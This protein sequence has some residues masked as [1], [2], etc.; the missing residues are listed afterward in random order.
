[1]TLQFLRMGTKMLMKNM[2]KKHF[3]CVFLCFLE[4]YKQLDKTVTLHAKSRTKKS[5]TSLIIKYNTQSQIST[6]G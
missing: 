5:F 2:Q 3:E 6:L 4:H 1:M